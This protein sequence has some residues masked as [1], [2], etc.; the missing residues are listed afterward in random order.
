LAVYNGKEYFVAAQNGSW[1]GFPLGVTRC[2]VPDGWSRPNHAGCTQ[3]LNAP[4]GH[5]SAH[6]YNAPGTPSAIVTTYD[7]ASNGNW[8]TRWG[9]LKSEIYQV[10]LDSTP[11][12]PHINRLAHHYSDVS[13]I[14]GSAG[15]NPSGC[16]NFNS[17]W[18]QPHSTQSND[19]S[20]VYFGSSW[21]PKCS[22]EAFMI[23]LTPS[24]NTPPPATISA[25]DLNA[26]GVVDASDVQLGT[27]QVL[28]TAACSTADLNSDGKCN[29]VDLQRIINA[30]LGA[31]CRVGL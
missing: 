22:A 18:A 2:E 30:S 11:T 7:N 20:K 9:P 12:T 17:Y 27:M 15:T 19:G 25:C 29:V 4:A 5:I 13:Y 14:E 6:A 8:N 24:A 26:D 23:S 21:G 31:S 10:Y 3:M 28:G 16:P 1:P